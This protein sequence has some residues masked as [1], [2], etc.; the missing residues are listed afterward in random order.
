M[1]G[2]IIGM[3]T[4]RKSLVYS[5][6]TKGRISKNAPRVCGTSKSRKNVTTVPSWQMNGT[7]MGKANVKGVSLYHG[8]IEMRRFFSG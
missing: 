7:S 3:V 2:E 6:D 8:T 4:T 1:G 5:A